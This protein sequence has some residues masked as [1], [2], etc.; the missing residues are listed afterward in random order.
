M[1]QPLLVYSP[2][3]FAF[4]S[5][6][7]PVTRPY[8]DNNIIATICID[9]F[10]HRLTVAQEMSF[11]FFYKKENRLKTLELHDR[12][13]MLDNKTTCGVN[14]EQMGKRTQLTDICRVG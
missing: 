14:G 7:P 6:I 11:D 5:H 2:E 1:K 13:C 3:C 4:G 10:S 9:C 12:K 8:Q